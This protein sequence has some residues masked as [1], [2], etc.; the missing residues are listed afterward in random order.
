MTERVI[1]ILSEF[2][3]IEKEKLTVQSRLIADLGLNSLDVINRVVA[4]EEEFDIE[5]PDQDIKELTSV[6]D[7]VSYLETHI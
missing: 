7:I 3:E 2:G 4:F 5:I 1:D 6:G